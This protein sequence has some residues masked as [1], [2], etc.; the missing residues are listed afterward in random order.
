MGW[1]EK[2]V[3]SGQ[4]LLEPVVGCRRVALENPAHVSIRWWMKGWGI[5]KQL[6]PASVVRKR[7]VGCIALTLALGLTKFAV[8]AHAGS[9]PC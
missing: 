5:H 6:F 2:A 1:S 7:V 3:S 8:D 4:W 9:W